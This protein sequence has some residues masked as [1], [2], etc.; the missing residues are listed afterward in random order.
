MGKVTIGLAKLEVAPLASDGGPG[1]TFVQIGFTSKGTFQ[2]QEEDPTKKTV[3][4][5]EKTDPL[6][7]FKKAGARSL[8]FSLADPDTEALALVRGGEITTV[9]S[10]TTVKGTKTYEEDA[11]VSY[12][13]TIR[14][15]PEE[16]FKTIVYNHVSLSGKLNGGLGAEQELLLEIACDILTPSKAGVKTAVIVEELP[17]AEA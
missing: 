1:T 6:K 12:E 17:L 5:E 13:C 7:V 3:D 14:V 11:A 16:G 10:T 2:F 15:T 4:V 9:A 8:V